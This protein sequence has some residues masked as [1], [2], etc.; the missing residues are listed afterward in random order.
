MVF[1][2]YFLFLIFTN[3][4]NFSH[5][6]QIPHPSWHMLQL[7][8]VDLIFCV[9]LNL[10]H[11]HFGL[12]KHNHIDIVLLE[13]VGQKHWALVSEFPIFLPRLTDIIDG[14]GLDF[15]KHLGADFEASTLCERPL[16]LDSACKDALDLNCL[17][18]F[19]NFFAYFFE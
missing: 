14:V 18:H 12:E 8:G 13:L 11:R 2:I 9:P 16:A 15:E 4:Y 17:L 19:F 10:I 1:P 3:D 5:P 6:I 7:N